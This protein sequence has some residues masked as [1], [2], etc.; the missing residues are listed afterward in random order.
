MKPHV[1]KAKPQTQPLKTETVLVTG[2]HQAHAQHLQ[3]TPQSVTTVSAAQ[4]EQTHETS[5]V[6]IQRDIPSLQILGFNPRNVEI[7]V[8]G[9]GLNTGG[10]NDNIEQGVG[11]YLDD[12]YYARPSVAYFDLP[13]LESVDVFRGPQ[14][15]DGGNTDPAGSV[16]VSTKLPDVTPHAE[17]DI[18][19]GDY[20][21]LRARADVTGSLFNSDTVSFRLT[22][23]SSS[24]D[25]YDYNTYSHSNVDNLNDHGVR[26]QLLFQPND[27]LSL[28]LIADYNNQ[29]EQTGFYVPIAP[30]ATTLADG[31]HVTGFYTKAA[32]LDY[33][34]LPFDPSTRLVDFDTSDRLRMETGGTSANL[35][36]ILP[37]QATLR[38]I[39]AYR[40]WTWSPSIDGD[41]IGLPIV[42]A[43]NLPTRQR[44]FSEELRIES[45]P[46]RMLEYKAGLYYLWQDSIDN[47][48]TSY[49]SAATQW[50]VGNS[51]PA[52]SLTNLTSYANIRWAS[53]NYAAYGQTVLHITPKLS[54]TTGVRYSYEDK[55]GTYDAFPIGDVVPTSDY[56]ASIRNSI[57]TLRGKY[58]PTLAYGAKTHDQAPDG[59]I[60]LSYAIQPGLMGY[61]TFAHG[62]KAGALNLTAVSVGRIIA[63]ET[64]DD[65]EGGLKETLLDGKLLI[66]A[67]LFWENDHNYQASYT[68]PTLRV[69]Y[70]TN[71][72]EVISRGAELDVHAMPVRGLTLSLSGTYDDAYYDSYKNAPC[73]WLLS[74]HPSCDISG[75]RLAGVSRWTIFGAANYEYPLTRRLV[76]YGGAD[77][78]FRSPYNGTLND[79]PYGAISAT[80]ILGLHAGLHAPKGL[81]DIS[82]WVRNALD[83]VYYTNTTVATTSGIAAATLGEPR[84]FGVT[85]KASL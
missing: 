77:Y 17:A 46:S 58:A 8:R 52:S 43:G 32:R 18:T 4:L 60:S 14:G 30:L 54:L 21:T 82:V 80:S 48:F 9:L 51:L 56:P 49:G 50:I 24:H 40:Y 11:V 34:P 76:A 2:A 64:V 75:S 35:A 44:Q 16:R 25:G 72:G 42:T 33:T 37:S 78:S 13:D 69:S 62:Y 29:I 20:N 26:G 3:N 67:D 85:L 84:I 12:V 79:D 31:T 38:S 57:A 45:A 19:Y 23:V 47:Q 61:A 68:D 10:T 27:R 73:P 6:E 7:L 36:Y 1:K 22:A 74:D 53:A 70:I 39:S 63:P 59:R 5:L 55:R 28:R 66:A 65:F 81:W 83:T 71:T 41:Y 15:T